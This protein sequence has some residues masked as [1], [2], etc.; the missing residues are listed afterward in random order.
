[1]DAYSAQVYK[2][3]ILKLQRSSAVSPPF[4]LC[5]LGYCTALDGDFTPLYCVQ[6]LS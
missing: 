4:S 3:S 6:A 5:S 2:R 1:M